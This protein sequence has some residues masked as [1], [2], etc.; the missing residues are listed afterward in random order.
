MPNAPD[1][2][3][4]LECNGF[5][6]TNETGGPPHVNSLTFQVEKLIKAAEVPRIR[7]R[8]SRHT[9]GALCWPKIST[10]GSCKSAWGT[11][12]LV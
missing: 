4:L 10:L 3:N 11:P 7:V 2:G 8:V 9:S 1:W 5:V 12:T 6:F